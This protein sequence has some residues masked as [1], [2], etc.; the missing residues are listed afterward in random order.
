MF[1]EN[2]LRSHGCSSLWWS[3]W[4]RWN[5][6]EPLWHP[7]SYRVDQGSWDHISVVL[8]CR[9]ELEWLC[10]TH[11]INLMWNPWHSGLEVQWK[12]DKLARRGPM[13]GPE[14]V[15]SLPF[16]SVSKN[17]HNWIDQDDKRPGLC[18]SGVL[19][20]PAIWPD[21][22]RGRWNTAGRRSKMR[23]VTGLLTRH[24]TV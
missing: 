3:V 16:Y 10:N 14:T 5:G 8:Y 1:R 22:W 21:F 15:V 24:N 9:E 18:Q 19:I 6:D 11:Q 23:V 2:K 12:A 20:S 4:K 13:M 17:V 7:G